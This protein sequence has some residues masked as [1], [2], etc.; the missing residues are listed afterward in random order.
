MVSVSKN[1]FIK[2]YLQNKTV[3]NAPLHVSL[4]SVMSKS[5]INYYLISYIFFIVQK[6][7][8]K[9]SAAKVWGCGREQKK[10]RTKRK[11]RMR[12]MRRRRR[13]KRRRLRRKAP[14][15]RRR[16]RRK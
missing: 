12:M 13:G 16:R 3:T 7:L 11:R 8:H 5:L 9:V 6:V 14:R 1:V 15:L 10:R 4:F 2:L